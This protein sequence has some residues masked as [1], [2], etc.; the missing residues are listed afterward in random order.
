MRLVEVEQASQSPSTRGLK[1][2]CHCAHD[3]SIPGSFAVVCSQEMDAEIVY[4]EPHADE[5][6]ESNSEQPFMNSYCLL[7]I[8][9]KPRLGQEGQRWFCTC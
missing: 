8:I 4:T 7:G 9:A 6:A 2:I 5:L 3:R 1:D